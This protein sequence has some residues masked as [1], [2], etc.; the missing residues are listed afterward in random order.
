MG[1]CQIW[2]LL[3]YV[4]TQ[5]GN[6]WGGKYLQMTTFTTCLLPYC[7][8]SKHTRC[9]VSVVTEERWRKTCLVLRSRDKAKIQPRTG[10]ESP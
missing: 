10:H 8:S 2:L 6:H 9:T 4:S 3:G 7:Y 1:L 5:D